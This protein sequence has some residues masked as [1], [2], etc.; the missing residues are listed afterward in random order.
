MQPEPEEEMKLRY[1]TMIA[2]FVILVTMVT[3]CGATDAPPTSA[4]VQPTATSA[5]ETAVSAEIDQLFEDYVAAF[6]AYDADAFQALLTE[7]YTAYLT[8]DD[9]R[10][11]ISS[12]IATTLPREWVIAR[13]KSEFPNLEFH[14]ERRG[15]AIMSGDGPWLVSQ[16]ILKT[17]KDPQ[18][19][20]GI[21]GV[22]TLTVIDEGGTLK[23]AREIYV[24]LEVK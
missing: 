7:G 24:Q 3:A 13:L 2:A 1:G 23:V 14:L 20:N 15:E 22:M 10:Y 5:P 12:G 4:P 19:P 17:I 9:S 16:V 6:N 21:E 11:A 8:A 18:Y